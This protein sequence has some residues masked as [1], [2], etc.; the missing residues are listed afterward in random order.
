MPENSKHPGTYRMKIYCPFVYYPQDPKSSV[1]TGCRPPD[2][3][4]KF[5][6]AAAAAAV[7]VV[8]VTM[9]RRRHTGQRTVRQGQLPC[10]KS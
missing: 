8:V 5:A 3:V 4:T 1:A 6:V 7:V 9:L 2:V 10:R